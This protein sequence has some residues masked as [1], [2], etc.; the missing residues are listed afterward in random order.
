MTVYR[1][2]RTGQTQEV[3]ERETVRRK[4]LE[5]AGW[6]PDSDLVQRVPAPAGVTVKI[7]DDVVTLPAG[8]QPMAK[9]GFKLVDVTDN[10]SDMPEFI[11]VPDDA[12]K[13]KRSK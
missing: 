2:P 10:G 11:E 6:V 7:G 4:I 3:D 8:E 9:P 5:Q 1:D 12:P 13:R